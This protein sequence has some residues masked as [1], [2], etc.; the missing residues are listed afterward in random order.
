MEAHTLATN[1]TQPA[2]AG[3]PCCRRWHGR[4][5]RRWRCRHQ[6]PVRPTTLP[7]PGGGHPRCRRRHR[8]LRER[9]I[10]RERERERR[11]EKN[12]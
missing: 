9:E 10:K 6:T 7:L 3:P 12:T 2:V 5:L 11:A 1:P 4:R 8:L